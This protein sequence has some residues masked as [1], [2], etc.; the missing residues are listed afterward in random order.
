[1]VKDILDRAGFKPKI[2]VE[3]SGQV[4]LLVERLQAARKRV[5]PPL[6]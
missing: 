4:S 1:M 5:T 2:E 3:H 6:A